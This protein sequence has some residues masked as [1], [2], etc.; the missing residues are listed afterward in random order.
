MSVGNNK[1]QLHCEL[2]NNFESCFPECYYMVAFGVL[3]RICE[4]S[5]YVY[6]LKK[7]LNNVIKMSAPHSNISTFVVPV[8]CQNYGKWKMEREVCKKLQVVWFCGVCFFFWRGG[9]CC[10][11]VG[12]FCLFRGVVVFLVWL[13]VVLF[14]I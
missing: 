2:N 9:E 14:G 8:L 4:H 13:L 3:G 1:N 7:G 12:F 10:C 11:L 6:K 5:I